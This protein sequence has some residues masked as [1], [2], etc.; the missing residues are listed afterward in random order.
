MIDDEGVAT[1]AGVTYVSSDSYSV[2]IKVPGTGKYAVRDKSTLTTASA[3]TDKTTKNSANLL[4][5]IALIALFLL[6]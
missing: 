4:S 2:T 3:S 5:F 1:T 6:H